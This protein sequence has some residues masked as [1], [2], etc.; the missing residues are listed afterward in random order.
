MNDATPS[1]RWF[2]FGARAQH[3]FEDEPAI[4]CFIGKL[5]HYWEGRNAWWGTWCEQY[6]GDNSFALAFEEVKERV[7][8]KRTRGSQWRISELPAL[9]LAGHYDALVVAEINTDSPL[10]EIRLPNTFDLSLESLAETFA[11]QRPNSICRF[12][13]DKSLMA[14]ARFPFNRYRSKSF[15][16]NYELGWSVANGG[17]ELLPLLSIVTHVCKRLQKR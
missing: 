12:V 6:P 15:G 17:V 2:S 16:G 10:S 5:F 9:V 14:P 3:D 13:A 4:S 8:R 1:P 11:P 7:E